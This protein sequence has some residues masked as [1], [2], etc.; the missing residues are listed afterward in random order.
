MTEA[1]VSLND[2]TDGLTGESVSLADFAEEPGGAWSPGWYKAEI[3]EGYSTAKSGKQFN[4]EDTVSK[5]G[6]SRNLRLCFRL[7]NAKGDER[8]MQESLNYRPQDF[9]SERLSFIKEMRVEFKNARRWPDTDAQ[10][11]SLAIAKIGQLQN[12]VGFKQLKIVNGGVAATT[13]VGQA[14]DV[15]LAMDDNGYNVITAFSTA[16]SKTGGTKK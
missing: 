6:D 3:I 5:N 11:S 10:R 7:K 13:F 14:L 15:R 8:T 2:V 1:T 4:S 12:A 16:G 9:T